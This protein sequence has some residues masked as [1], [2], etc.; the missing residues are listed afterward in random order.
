MPEVCVC[1]SR[2]CC[3]S[4]VTDGMSTVPVLL[5]TAVVYDTFKE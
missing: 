4:Q 3:A 1:V 5:D 2:I